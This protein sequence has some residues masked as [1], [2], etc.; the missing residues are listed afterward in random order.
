LQVACED[1]VSAARV[2]VVANGHMSAD[3]SYSLE[4]NWVRGFTVLEHD[5]TAG[6][7]HPYPVVVRDGRF[8]WRGR[9]FGH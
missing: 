3:H 7:V 5:V 2:F 1:L 8:A 6:F 4:N 9:V